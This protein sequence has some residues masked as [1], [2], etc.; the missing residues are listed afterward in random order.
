MTPKQNWIEGNL[1]QE[2]GD[3]LWVRMWGVIVAYSYTV[4]A[5]LRKLR[6]RL[7]LM[8]IHPIGVKYPTFFILR[9]TTLCSAFI[10]VTLS[11]FLTGKIK[12]GT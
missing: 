3:Y 1:P 5:T 8:L 12:N 11:L 7:T 4:F 10:L 9:K 2:A 6:E